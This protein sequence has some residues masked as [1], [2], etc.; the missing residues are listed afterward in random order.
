MMNFMTRAPLKGLPR[1]FEARECDAEPA[2]AK[3]PRAHPPQPGHEP[4]RGR[5]EA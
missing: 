4:R 1:G 3:V 5:A 2:R